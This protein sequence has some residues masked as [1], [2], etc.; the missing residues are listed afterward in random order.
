MK[1]KINYSIRTAVLIPV[2]ILGIFAVVSN[3]LA[4]RNV[5]SV[6]KSGTDIANVYM[7]SISDMSDIQSTIQ[8]IHKEAL[9]HIIATQ[10]D[11]MIRIVDEMDG[12]QLQLEEDLQE[13]QKYVTADTAEEYNKLIDN[14]GAYKDTMM[15]LIAYSA[16]SDTTAAYECA[17]NEFEEYRIAIMNSISAL[18]DVARQQADEAKTSLAVTYNGARALS[19][20]AIILSVL[21]VAVVVAVV[22]IVVIRPIRKMESQIS[23]IMT[24]ID[25]RQGDLTKRLTICQVTELANLGSGVNNFII[26]LQNIFHTISDNSDKIDVVVKEVMESVV[27]SGDSVTDLSALTEEISATMT[28]VSSN[29]ENINDSTQI[30][31]E[32][33]RAIAERSSELK[34]YSVDMKRQA[35]AVEHSARANLA[36]TEQKVNEILHVLNQ[37]IEESKSVEQVNTLTSGILEIA[38]QTNLLA[39]N[40]SIEAARA[41]EA[42]KGFAVVAEEIRQLA[43]SSTENANRIQAINTSVVAAVHN[44]VDNANNLVTYMNESILPEFEE[45]VQTGVKYEENADYV[46]NA[47]NEFAQNTLNLRESIETM[48]SALNTIT[49]ALNDGVE[50]VSGVANN[51]QELVGDMENIVKRMDENQQISESLSKETAI[52]VRL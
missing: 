31:N 8:T 23:E 12:L 16:G 7:E 4:F 13:Y 49:S 9:S 19:I 34:E 33:V 38:D 32:E 51:T 18:N 43:E 6:N 26:K 48:S 11:T 1:H 17:N 52:F 10:F 21:F 29:V 22:L 30:I 24:D 42:G 25:N 5:K 28:D 47:M 37:A 20:L 35:D 50:G 39:L 14:Y 2:L 27:T 46:E 36:S 41:G 44:L 3:M 40:A 45:F 15:N